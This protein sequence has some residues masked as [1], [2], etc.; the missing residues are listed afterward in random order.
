MR[1]QFWNSIGNVYWRRVWLTSLAVSVAW[2]AFATVVPQK[3]YIWVLA[4]AGGTSIFTGIL[5]RG[6]KF[7]QDRNLELPPGGQ[8]P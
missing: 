5:I 1:P 7:V 3:Y 4:L 6:V 2:G 8:N